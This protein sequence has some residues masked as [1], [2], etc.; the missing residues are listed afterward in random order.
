MPLRSLITRSIAQTTMVVS[1]PE[2]AYGAHA[3]LGIQGQ[4]SDKPLIEV[5]MEKEHVIPLGSDSKLPRYATTRSSFNEALAE[6]LNT[7]L[8]KRRESRFT[9]PPP[10]PLL[11]ERQY[12]TQGSAGWQM[13]RVRRMDGAVTYI[14]AGT[15]VLHQFDGASAHHLPSMKSSR[16]LRHALHASPDTIEQ[17][18]GKWVFC[19]W[20]PGS[21]ELHAVRLEPEHEASSNPLAIS[22]DGNDAPS[23]PTPEPPQSLRGRTARCPRC[24]HEW[25]E[26]L[27]T[28]SL[29]IR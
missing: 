16:A 17:N 13:V 26:P 2:G 14:P 8:L 15:K 1:L 25:R 18:R 3:V 4:V 24:H 10:P 7:I 5:M 23:R 19:E 11:L 6:L 21:P 20:T 22:T 27:S 28:P 29:S 12:P 9:P